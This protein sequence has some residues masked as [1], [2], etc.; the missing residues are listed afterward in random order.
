MSTKHS[1]KITKPTNDESTP[2][3]EVQL[4]ILAIESDPTPTPPADGIEP[5]K[6]PMP[7]AVSFDLSVPILEFLT[8]PTM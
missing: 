7:Q 3:E 1:T 6:L 5:E 8:D 4:P 2:D